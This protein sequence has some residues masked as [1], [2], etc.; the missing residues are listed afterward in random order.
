[1]KRSR[2]LNQQANDDI[3]K[4]QKVFQRGGNKIAIHF[5]G[6]GIQSAVVRRIE[7]EDTHFVVGCVAWL[8]NK[9]ILKAMAK[10][11]GICIICTKDRLTKRRKNQNAYSSLKPCFQ[12]GVIRVVGE[13]RGRYKSLMHHKFLVGLDA[14]R[15]P[16]WVVNGSFNM[17]ENALNNIENCMELQDPDIAESFFQEFKR[18]HRVSTPLKIVKHRK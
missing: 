15:Q 6:R 10:K 13:G 1:M 17:T 3:R 9:R 18:I 14:E 11:K 4:R 12:G 7:E 8:S 16:L 5:N 2:D